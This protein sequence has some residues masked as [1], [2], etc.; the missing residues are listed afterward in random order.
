[1]WAGKQRP[2]IE[3]LDPVVAATAFVPGL[4]PFPA[5]I[6]IGDPYQTANRPRGIRVR[7]QAFEGPCTF[8]LHVDASLRRPAIGHGEQ[9]RPRERLR[10]CGRA[11]WSERVP[12]RG[13][14]RQLRRD[15]D[16]QTRSRVRNAHCRPGR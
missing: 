10:Q 6:Q 16:R 11:A 3:S 4:E 12:A 2:R 8:E 5:P 7:Q 1:M 14:T 9:Q 13:F 15:A